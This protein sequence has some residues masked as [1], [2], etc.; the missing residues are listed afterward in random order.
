MAMLSP[1]VTTRGV[2]A[3]DVELGALLVERRFSEE[4]QMAQAYRWQPLADGDVGDTSWYG[5]LTFL[6]S[7]AAKLLE[8]TAPGGSQANR[9]RAR[10]R[11]DSGE[12]DDD[13]PEWQSARQSPHRFTGAPWACELI[14]NCLQAKGTV[15]ERIAELPRPLLKAAAGHYEMCHA[16]PPPDELE[17]IK[18]TRG[19]IATP[20]APHSYGHT[21]VC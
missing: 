9:R 16:A 6:V 10:D 3:D 11:K 21:L 14:D 4:A 7:G 1:N 8:A 18:V 17:A 13:L 20:T 5:T 2:A 15:V 12:S 19:H